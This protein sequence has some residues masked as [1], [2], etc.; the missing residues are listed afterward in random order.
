MDKC[1]DIVCNLRFKTFLTR[2]Q[3]C[4]WTFPAVGRQ[5]WETKCWLKPKPD[6]LFTLCWVSTTEQMRIHKNTIPHMQSAERPQL[7]FSEANWRA[8]SCVWVYV[9]RTQLQPPG[10]N[11]LPHIKRR[12][13]RQSSWTNTAWKQ[14][15]LNRWRAAAASR[16]AA[17]TGELSWRRRWLVHC[18]M[19]GTEQNLRHGFPSAGC[20]FPSSSLSEFIKLRRVVLMTCTETVTKNDPTAEKW[21]Q[22]HSFVP[23]SNNK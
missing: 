6:R 17:L 12:S 2:V 3:I 16:T 21:V 13:W 1:S 23:F 11:T 10:Q 5:P 15:P 14:Y 8:Q 20:T 4:W 7:W 22:I 9:G 18:D 19:S